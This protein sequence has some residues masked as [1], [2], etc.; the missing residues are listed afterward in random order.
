MQIRFWIDVEGD[1]VAKVLSPEIGN[2]FDILAPTNIFTDLANKSEVV[3]YTVW[4]I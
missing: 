4:L 1:E 3:A 2:S